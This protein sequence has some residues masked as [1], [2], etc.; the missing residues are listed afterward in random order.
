[1]SENGGNVLEEMFWLQEIT[2]GCL[3]YENHKGLI[4]R[5]LHSVVIGYFNKY[6]LVKY[7][8]IPSYINQTMV[9]SEIK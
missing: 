7:N 3:G 9:G 6:V 1:M 5:L 8:Q 4:L 2:S